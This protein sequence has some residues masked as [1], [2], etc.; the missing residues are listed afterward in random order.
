MY[1]RDLGQEDS[2][3]DLKFNYGE[4]LLKAVL[5]K[6]VSG[7]GALYVSSGSANGYACMLQPSLRL[8]RACKIVNCRADL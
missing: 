4:N 1:A 5:E 3:D 7:L 2:A 8:A 6:W